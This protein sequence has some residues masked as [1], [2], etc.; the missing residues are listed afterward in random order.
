MENY[1]TSLEV[2]PALGRRRDHI[3]SSL[4]SRHA[5]RRLS[6]DLNICLKQM[7]ILFDIAS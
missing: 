6:H 3:E 5:T 4:F 2:V 7:H 1:G